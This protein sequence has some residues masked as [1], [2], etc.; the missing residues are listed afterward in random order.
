MTGIL[1]KIY[2]AGFSAYLHSFDAVDSWL[3]STSMLLTIRS[4]KQCLCDRTN[5]QTGVQILTNAG[6]P[7]L[8]R[9]FENLRY[10]GIN[11]ADAV[12]ADKNCTLYLHCVDSVNDDYSSFNLLQYFL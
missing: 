10:R 7:D 11:F 12:L 1:E 2:T 4:H 3:D 6:T 8:T 9:L 5:G